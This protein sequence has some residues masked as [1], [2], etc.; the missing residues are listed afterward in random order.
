MAAVAALW[1]DS[2]RSAQGA[3]CAQSFARINPCDAQGL[4]WIARCLTYASS[5]C[6]PLAVGLRNTADLRAIRE[7]FGA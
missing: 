7:S 5:V 2:G 4:A 3:G 1:H 6:M